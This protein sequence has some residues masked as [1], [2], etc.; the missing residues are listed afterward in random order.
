[1]QGRGTLHAHGLVFINGLNPSSIEQYLDNEAATRAISARLMAIVSANVPETSDVSSAADSDTST[2]TPDMVLSA[3]HRAV[4]QAHPPA[5]S[6]S[7][8]SA[9]AMHAS[10]NGA[11]AQGQTMGSVNEAD[12]AASAGAGEAAASAG[13][14]EADS[15]ALSCLCN[16]HRM[17]PIPSTRVTQPTAI[18]RNLE[19]PVELFYRYL[20]NI[21]IAVNT[22]RHSF[23]CAKHAKAQR[24]RGEPCTCRL[25]FPQR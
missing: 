20:R 4:C 15:A 12:S 14:G 16:W 21:V 2:S 6:S 24:D 25:M 8:R 10:N 22:H 5:A 23:T 18:G 13:A 11:N 17:S 1:M 7:V 9:A 19:V 3:L